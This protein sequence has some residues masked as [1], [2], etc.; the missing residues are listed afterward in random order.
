MAHGFPVR[1][2]RGEPFLLVSFGD[3]NDPV[4]SPA[5]TSDLNA[6]R[7]FLKAAGAGLVG[8]ELIS[9]PGTL[10]AQNIGQYSLALPVTRLGAKGDGKTLDTPA[11]NN[12][13]DAVSRAGGGIIFFPAGTYLCHSIHLKSHVTLH[14]AP[15]ATI[16]AADAIGPGGHGGLLKSKSVT[17]V[18]R[19]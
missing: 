7:R 12:A 10:D 6:R 17:L 3:G 14:L 1:I 2:S 16:L 4:L 15:G 11:I 8:S 13:I 19:A 9:L 18:T 5:M